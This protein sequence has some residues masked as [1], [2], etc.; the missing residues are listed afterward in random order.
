MQERHLRIEQNPID[1]RVIHV[2]RANFN[3]RQGAATSEG[4]I[5]NAGN[6]V[7]NGD[8]RQAAAVIEGKRPDAGDRITLNGVGNDQLAG[9]G[10]ITI[11]NGDFAI[12]RG[13]SQV[14]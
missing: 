10:F 2:P 3:S 13:P 11:G 1:L 14:A 4:S 6:A 5:P 9:G 7:T 8:T 12:S